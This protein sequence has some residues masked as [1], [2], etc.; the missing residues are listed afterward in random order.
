MLAGFNSLLRGSVK[1]WCLVWQRLEIVTTCN[2][3]QGC[4]TIDQDHQLEKGSQSKKR[5][6]EVL[7]KSQLASA[8]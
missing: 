6:R 3:K 4:S 7:A 5:Y 8:V 1:E 2:A